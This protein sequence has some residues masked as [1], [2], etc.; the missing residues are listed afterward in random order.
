[1]IFFSADQKRVNMLPRQLNNQKT[2]VWKSVIWDKVNSDFNKQ[3]AIKKIQ[4]PKK[5]HCKS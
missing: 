5:L 3:L 2:Y 4:I 1:M